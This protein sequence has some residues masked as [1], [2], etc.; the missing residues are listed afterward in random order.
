MA[1]FFRELGKM[2]GEQVRRTTWVLQALTGSDAEALAAEFNMGQ[3]L[4]RQVELEFEVDVDPGLRD[5][6]AGIAAPLTARLTNKKRRFQ[7]GVLNLPDPNAFALPG[8]FIWLHRPLL[9]LCEWSVDELA[10]VMGHEV[11]H[12]VRRHALE[13]LAASKLIGGAM[14]MASAGGV[15]GPLQTI[16]A[17]ILT[18][19]YSQDNELDADEFGLR[20]ARSAGF[21]AGAAA[22]TLSRF[23]ALGG[24]QPLLSTYFSSHPPATLRVSR[25]REV[26]DSAS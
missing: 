26:I 12:V 13:R 22:R 19:G 10:W 17:R 4:S 20:L 14:A 24:N 1:G 25:I 21:D 18:S 16:V 11:A 9:E 3:H 23:E 7:F 6:V 8:G 5:F 2:C 15:G